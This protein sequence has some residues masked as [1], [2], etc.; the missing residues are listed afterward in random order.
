M[1]VANAQG[2]TV[3]LQKNSNSYRPIGVSLAGQPD[4]FRCKTQDSFVNYGCVNTLPSPFDASVFDYG[5]GGYTDFNDVVQAYVFR[6]TGPGGTPV[7]E[8]KWTKR[9]P[10]DSF[11]PDG[12]LHVDGGL[13]RFCYYGGAYHLL[14]TKRKA[15]LWKIEL[16]ADTVIQ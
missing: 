12:Y 1:S 15:G 11:C 7:N 10:T 8:F 4:I 3:V 14:K 16:L 6:F 13:N 9:P 5:I 2:D